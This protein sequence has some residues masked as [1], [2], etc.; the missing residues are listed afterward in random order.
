[1]ARTSAENKLI[2]LRPGKGLESGMMPSVLPSAGAV[3]R[4]G[5]QVWFQDA[6]ISEALGE[7]L[8]ISPVHR[9][10]RAMAQAYVSGKPRLYFEDLG[11]ISYFEEGAPAQIIGSL[12]ANSTTYDFAP[13]GT[14]LA[15]TDNVGQPKLWK[16]VPPFLDIGTGEFTRAKMLKKLGQYLLAFNTD[17]LPSGFHWSDASD[18]ETWTPD[19][20]NTAGN[21]PIRDLDSDIVAVADLGAALALYSR[22]YM[23]LLQYVG[24]PDV[25]GFPN[26]ALS[27]IGAASMHSVVSLGRDNWGLCRG[28]IFTTNGSSFEYVDKPAVARWLQENVDWDRSD[29]ITSYYD[30]Q[31]ELVVWSVPTTGGDFREIAVSPKNRSSLLQASPRTFTFLGTGF[32]AALERGVFGF[33]IVAKA[34]GIYRHSLYNSTHADFLLQSQLWAAGNQ[35]IYKAWNYAIFEGTITDDAQVRF[36]FTDSDELASIEWLPW[37][38][39]AYQVAFGPR[40][41]VFMAMEIQSKKPLAISAITIFGDNAGSVA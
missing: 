2:E 30:E 26:Q 10:P 6:Q 13:W 40:E 35:A 34:D 7:T 31:M 8:L 15:M 22:E 38:S 33:P 24:Y 32:G 37:R 12:N 21:L 3:W 11:I 1:M 14:W 5:R 23:L 9:K 16:G 39:L 18:P 29:E 25:F 28:G 17:V 19:F 20:F 4:D 27:G 41:S 36:G